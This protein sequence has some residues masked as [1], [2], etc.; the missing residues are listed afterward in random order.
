M[1]KNLKVDYNQVLPEFYDENS[2]RN[3]VA[4]AQPLQKDEVIEI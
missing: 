3:S 4:N 2:T 1:L